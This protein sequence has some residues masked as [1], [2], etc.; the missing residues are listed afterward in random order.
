MILEKIFFKSPLYGQKTKIIKTMQ[1]SKFFTNSEFCIAIL[2]FI[3]L[4]FFPTLGAKYTE[5]LIFVQNVNTQYVGL[6]IFNS[7]SNT[8]NAECRS[9]FDDVASLIF[10]IFFFKNFK[11]LLITRM[12]LLAFFNS[13]LLL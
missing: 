6:R 12:C 4:F 2:H 7:F 10:T 11:T 13:G 1:S 3:Y 5:I 8:N 9:S